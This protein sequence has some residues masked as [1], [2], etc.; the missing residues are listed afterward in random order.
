[1]TSQL[2]IE[3]FT[4]VYF[5]SCFYLKYWRKKFFKK[6]IILRYKKNFLLLLHIIS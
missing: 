5:V 6:R 2:S 3:N 4:K 1:M